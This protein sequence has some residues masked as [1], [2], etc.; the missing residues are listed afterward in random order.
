MVI[1]ASFFQ[2]VG[3]ILS[4][5]FKS[6]ATQGDIESQG[7]DQAEHSSQEPHESSKL[8]AALLSF[9]VTVCD[10]L[11]SRGESLAERV[12]A[13]ADSTFSNIPRML[14]EMVE[15]NKTTD[16]TFF[17]GKK[18]KDYRQDGN[19]LKIMK[20][21]SKM[22]ISMMNHNDR[23]ADEDLESLIRYMEHTSSEIT[24]NLKGIII[25]SKRKHGATSPVKSTLSSLVKKAQELV[26]EKKT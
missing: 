7:G 12:A 17:K 14:K 1:T 15:R 24:N 18:R 22:A 6:S 25:S 9:C 20:L 8:Q 19:C 13:T 21:T 3:T 4:L 11:I 2:D 5:I 10:K 23:Y 16:R 26:I